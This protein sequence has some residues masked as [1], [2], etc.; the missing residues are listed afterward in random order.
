MGETQI[1]RQYQT[2]AMN[3]QGKLEPVIVVDFNVG[4]DGP[5]SVY[6]PVS[7]YTADRVRTEVQKLA[8]EIGQVQTT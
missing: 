7:E 6:V 5:F 8:L 1:I 4:T 3:P 2:S